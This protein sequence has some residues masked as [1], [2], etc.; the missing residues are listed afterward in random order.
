MNMTIHCQFQPHAGAFERILRVIRVRGFDI[1]QMTAGPASSGMMMEVTLSGSRCIIN[2]C[3]QL[4]KLQEVES[5]ALKANS[6]AS[7]RKL[8]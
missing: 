5:S 4:E 2:L 8:G 7:A 6:I 1:Q 3:H